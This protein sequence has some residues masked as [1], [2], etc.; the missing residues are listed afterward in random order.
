MTCL[1]IYR[2][3]YCLNQILYVCVGLVLVTDAIPAMGLPTGRHHMGT[4]EIKIN[5]KQATIA[6]LFSRIALKDIISMLKC[7]TWA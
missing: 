4:Q 7:A 5:G 6:I 1:V 2:I 3:K